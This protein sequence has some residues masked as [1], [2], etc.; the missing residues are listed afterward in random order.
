MS[1][2]RNVKY[3][4]INDDT[5]MS[6]MLESVDDFHDLTISCHSRAGSKVTVDLVIGDV[7]K[8]SL[9]ELSKA[10]LELSKLIKQASK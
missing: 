3:V 7:T 8:E 1:E 10:Y 9:R 6:I 2:I 4:G 5:S